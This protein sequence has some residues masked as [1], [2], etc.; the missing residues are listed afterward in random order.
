MEDFNSIL[1]FLKDIAKNNDLAWFE[2]NKARYLEVKNSFD[3]FLAS[4]LFFTTAWT[5]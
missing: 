3:D 4:L 1:K 2:K 5:D